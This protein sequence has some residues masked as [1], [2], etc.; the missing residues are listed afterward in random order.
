MDNWLC[1]PSSGGVLYR[2]VITKNIVDMVDKPRKENSTQAKLDYHYMYMII[3]S[4]L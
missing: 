4:F 2:F 3:V 1:V